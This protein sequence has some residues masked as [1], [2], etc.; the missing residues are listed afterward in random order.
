MLQKY[1]ST[2]P[3][4]KPLDAINFYYFTVKW[5]DITFKRIANRFQK[6]GNARLLLVKRAPHHSN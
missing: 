1:R 6:G 4:K 2:S 3:V 5:F